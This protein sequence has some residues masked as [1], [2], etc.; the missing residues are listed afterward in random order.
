MPR[1]R[2]NGLGAVL[3]V[4]PIPVVASVHRLRWKS[5]SGAHLL[6]ER[7]NRRERALVRVAG[8][9]DTMKSALVTGYLLCAFTVPMALAAIPGGWLSERLGYRY[10]TRHVHLGPPTAS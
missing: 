6:A 8:A 9:A 7:V 2:K 4:G 3:P 5:R 10:L 1:V